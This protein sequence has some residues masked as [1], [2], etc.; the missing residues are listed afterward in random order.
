MIHI[1]HTPFNNWTF[2]GHF[3]HIKF[4]KNP[5]YPT[6]GV[7]RDASREYDLYV[8]WSPKPWL[9][10]SVLGAVSVPKEGMRQ[11][12]RNNN[13]SVEPSHIGKKFYFTQFVATMSF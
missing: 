7:S 11:L 4:D 8:T 6:Q 3:Y 13:P 12:I 1:K 9:S 10:F 5:L 2:G